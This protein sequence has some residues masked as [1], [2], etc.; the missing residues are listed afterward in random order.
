MKGETVNIEYNFE[1]A[2]TFWM[3][4]LILQIN[5]LLRTMLLMSS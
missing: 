5:L 2:R 4:C 3:L 1:R